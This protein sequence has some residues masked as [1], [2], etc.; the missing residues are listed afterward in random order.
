M[1]N[2]PR[3]LLPGNRPHRHSQE[4][5]FSG[6]TVSGRV[7]PLHLNSGLW[8]WMQGAGRGGQ[9]AT[10]G[11]AVGMVRPAGLEPARCYSLEPESSASANSATGAHSSAE[12]VG[13]GSPADKSFFQ[14]VRVKGAS[15]HCPGTAWPRGAPI[16]DP[17]RFEAILPPGRVGDQ[18]SGAVSG[19]RPRPKTA[20]G[21][22]AR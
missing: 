7:T 10:E 1:Q 13:G 8:A 4:S 19:I 21:P 14:T 3:L 18:R 22:P 16:S 5:D 17:A 6:P 20:A 15:G 9:S 11:V 12:E 2:L